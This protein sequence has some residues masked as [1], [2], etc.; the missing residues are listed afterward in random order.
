MEGPSEFEIQLNSCRKTI[1]IR[2]KT[3]RKSIE[4]LLKFDQAS[5]EVLSKLFRKSIEIR[6]KL[7]ENYMTKRW[8]I[9]RRSIEDE[10]LTAKLARPPL[11]GERKPHL[12]SL[13]AELVAPTLPHLAATRRGD[14]LPQLSLG[15]SLTPRAA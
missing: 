10:R 3:Y 14:M 6:L 9:Y 12:P 8:K 5:I 15:S 2:F 11:S 4:I 7:Y 13:T 1:D